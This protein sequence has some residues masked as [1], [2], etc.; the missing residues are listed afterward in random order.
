ME[1][2]TKNCSLVR[3]SQQRSKSSSLRVIISGFSAFALVAAVCVLFDVSR[4]NG[5][6]SKLSQ[7]A[8]LA[9]GD[10]SF[11][12]D[13]SAVSREGSVRNNVKPDF[14]P[15]LGKLG[16]VGL[17]VEAKPQALAVSKIKTLPSLA[18][19]DASFHSDDPTSVKEGSV[20]KGIKPDFVPPLG[21]LGEVGLQSGVKPQALA[22][23]SHKAD[24]KLAFGDFS[25]HSDPS[26]NTKEGSI[27]EGVKP[28]Y[29]PPLGSL[30]EVGLK[31]GVVPQALAA[32]QPRNPLAQLAFGD[33]V[34]QPEKESPAAREGGVR[35]GVKP[36]FV[37]PI[38]DLGEIG[39]AKKSPVALH[40]Q[41][42]SLKPDVDATQNRPAA[43]PKIVSHSSALA[44][45]DATF[46]P[47]QSTPLSREGSVRG[48]K[49]P[50]FKPPIGDL[51]EVGLKAAVKGQTLAAAKKPA[52]PLVKNVAHG[53]KM[54]ADSS[55]ADVERFY[56]DQL[57]VLKGAKPAL[58][59]D[60]HHLSA[61]KAR[62]GLEAFYEAKA[63]RDTLS[64]SDVHASK[65]GSMSDTKAREGLEAFFAS[66]AVE[67]KAAQAKVKKASTKTALQGLSAYYAGKKAEDAAQHLKAVSLF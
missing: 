48:G 43:K 56:Q 42:L 53:A 17:K 25:I 4:G 57:R 50:D 5:G 61:A 29:L 20:R 19:G 54:S 41:S 18:F 51:G 7:V 36:D 27:R 8:A 46:V 16:E 35:E 34:F 12:V 10:S 40:G 28:D 62:A 26:P 64:N 11:H 33:A 59:E 6:N 32:S 49:R 24:S 58:R 38:G 31:S 2:G 22:I 30:G 39:L 60:A 21:T 14:V 55:R 65:A 3:P 45:G 66:K 44:F 47:S 63:K 15:P 37:P 9:F 67:A 1:I 52:V 13:A 23:A